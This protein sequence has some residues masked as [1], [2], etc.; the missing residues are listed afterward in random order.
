[1]PADAG[2]AVVA[3]SLLGD[4]RVWNGARPMLLAWS[5]MGSSVLTSSIVPFGHIV[6]Q[7]GRKTGRLAIKSS[8]T[9]MKL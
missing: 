5:L 2:A 8:C 1:M 9:E 6:G 4:R 3:R 7:D